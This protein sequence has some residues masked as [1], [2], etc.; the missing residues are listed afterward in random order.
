MS[1]EPDQI[2]N[3][4]HVMGIEDIENELDT[5]VDKGLTAYAHSERLEACG[6]N[7]IPEQKGATI[8]DL[9]WVQLNSM[10]IYILTIGAAISFG[11]NHLIDGAVIIGVVVINV[12]LGF[13]M[14][15]KAIS[16]TDSLK[17]MMSLRSLVIRDEEKVAVDATD[18][19]PGDIILL[20]PG[21]VVPADARI[22]KQNNLQ[23][24]EAALTGESHATAK[25]SEACTDSAVSL[26]DRKCM[27]F[28]G[29]KVIKGTPRAWSPAPAQNARSARSAACWQI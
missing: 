13:Y 22:V 25:N 18:L 14:E 16:S 21:D 28:S 12:G 9:L 15:R 24:V 2:E 29:T 11:F 27:V 8:L 20:Q 19:V 23:V 7:R 3:R 10:V 26:A 17:K 1:A 4:A 5:N 6:P